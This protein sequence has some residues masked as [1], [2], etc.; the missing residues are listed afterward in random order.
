MRKSIFNSGLY[1][2][3]VINLTLSPSCPGGPDG[4]GGPLCPYKAEI[5]CFKVYRASTHKKYIY[6][7]NLLY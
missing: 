2:R 4:P 1:S 7:N 3:N 6:V 5:T